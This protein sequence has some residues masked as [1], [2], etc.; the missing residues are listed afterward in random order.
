MLY[1]IRRS[2]EYIIKHY[3]END[4]KTPMHM[5]MGQEAIPTAICHALGEGGQVYATYRS[6]ATFLAK[7]ADTDQF[8]AELYGKVTGCSRGKAGSMHLVSPEKGHLSSSAV[9]ASCIPVTV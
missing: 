9:V 5:S 1:L 6:H 4:M 2:E 3:P 8:F 7:T